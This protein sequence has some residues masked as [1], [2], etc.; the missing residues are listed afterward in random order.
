MMELIP[1]NTFTQDD[2]LLEDN[3]HVRPLYYTEYIDTVKVDRILVDPGS[4]LDIM[5]KT[6]LDALKIPV[7]NL[8][9]TIT[10]IL[11][12][13]SGRSEPLGKIRLK[14]QIGNLR[15]KVTFYVIDNH[16]SY[17]VLLG[18]S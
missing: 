2:M 7:H 18:R 3:R 6:L 12:F 9:T 10:T 5:P 15:T 14:V 16:V 11:E 13:N 17:N 4:A 8:S 1:N